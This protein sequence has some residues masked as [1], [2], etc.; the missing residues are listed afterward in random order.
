MTV[1]ITIKHNG[2][3]KKIKVEEVDVE[4]RTEDGYWSDLSKVT[5]LD[6]GEELTTYI[7]STR[8]IRVLEVDEE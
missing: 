5:I 2:G 1:Q 3:P 7:W 8:D 6:I 4:D